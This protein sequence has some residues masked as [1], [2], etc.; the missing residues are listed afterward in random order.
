MLNLKSLMKSM[1]IEKRIEELI[2]SGNIKSVKYI[3]PMIKSI[4][5]QDLEKILEAKIDDDLS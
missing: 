2:R 3:D 5:K 4:Y 1:S